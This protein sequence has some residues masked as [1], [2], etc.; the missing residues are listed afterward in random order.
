M[1]KLKLFKKK[2]NSVI[3]VNNT[4]IFELNGISYSIRRDRRDT[5][6][7]LS[8]NYETLKYSFIILGNMNE[9]SGYSPYLVINSIDTSKKKAKELIGLSFKVTD[10]NQAREREDTFYIYEHEPIVEYEVKIL[11]IEEHQVHIS[12]TGKAI[13]DGYVDD[14]ETIDFSIDCFLP[15]ITNKD[16]WSKYGF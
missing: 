9:D 15:I 8:T 4:S 12:C 7:F 5:A 11:D 13:V 6:F 1:R 10:I 14:Y 16:D 2:E 3:T